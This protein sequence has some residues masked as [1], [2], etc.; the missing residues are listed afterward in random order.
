MI[1]GE[2]NDEEKMPIFEDDNDDCAKYLIER[3]AFMVKQ[4]LNLQVNVGNLKKQRENIFHARCHVQNKVCSM[5]NNSRSCT[6]VVSI[7]LVDKLDLHT[8]KYH[9]P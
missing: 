4:G 2:V 6:N 7:D 3:E 9:I 8:I 5:I 1:D